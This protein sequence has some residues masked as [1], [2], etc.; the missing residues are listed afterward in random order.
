MSLWLVKDSIV[1]G[2]REAYAHLCSIAEK[3]LFRSRMRCLIIEEEGY[4]DLSKYIN[5][6][7]DIGFTSY[8]MYDE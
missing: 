8:S 6:E 4:E 7:F 1:L 2:V 5:A 3:S